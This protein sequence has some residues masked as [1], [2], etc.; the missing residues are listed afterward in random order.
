MHSKLSFKTIEGTKNASPGPGAYAHSLKTLKQAPAFGIGTE[1]RGAG[2]VNKQAHENP[3]AGKYL[4]NI[5]MTLP[6]QAQWGF[7]TE[8]RTNEAAEKQ[9]KHMPGPGAYDLKPKAFGDHKF[10][11]GV[12]LKES[13]SMTAVP[14]SGAYD[15]QHKSILKSLPAFTMAARNDGKGKGSETKLPGPG[16]YDQLLTNKRNGPHYGFTKDSRD[17]KANRNTSVPGPGSYKLKATI[18]DM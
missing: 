13:A 6:S 14:G 7:G 4:P 17:E 8:K 9:L 18:G 11:Y 10:A 1:K 12:R 15:P 16:A 5:T 3:S 2:S